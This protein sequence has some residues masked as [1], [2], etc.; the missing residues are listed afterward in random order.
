M[1]V[2]HN[3]EPTNF[4]VRVR[5]RQG[6]LAPQERLVQNFEPFFEIKL[7]YHS[8]SSSGFY[9]NRKKFKFNT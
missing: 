5:V 3:G 6:S 1:G 4:T 9:E 8:I 2:C 7:N